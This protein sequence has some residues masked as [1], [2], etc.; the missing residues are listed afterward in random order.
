[1]GDFLYKPVKDKDT[2]EHFLPQHEL[3]CVSSSMQG[4]RA[5]MEDVCTVETRIPDFLNYSYFGVYDG[6]GGRTTADYIGANL[7]HNV[8]KNIRELGEE[9]IEKAIKDSFM[10]TD[11]EWKDKIN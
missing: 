11:S 2:I 4:W 9:N 1:M 6:H 5:K 3:I 8:F 10:Q 7:H